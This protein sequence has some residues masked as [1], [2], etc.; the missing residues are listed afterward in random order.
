MNVRLTSNEIRFR[1]TLEELR[2][3][4]AG[5]SL[6]ET[7]AFADSIFTVS[8]EAAQ[9]PGPTTVVAVPWRIHVSAASADLAALAA[10]RSKRGVE[11]QIGPVLLALQVDVRTHA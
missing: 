1:V 10:G 4:L 8:M 3:L 7:L 11:R 2:G 6:A 5:Q 9:E